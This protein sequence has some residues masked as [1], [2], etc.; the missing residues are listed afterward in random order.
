MDVEAARSVFL[1]KMLDFGFADSYDLVYRKGNKSYSA[2]VIVPAPPKRGKIEFCDHFLRLS[3]E[4]Q[5]QVAL[6]EI[7][8]CIDFARHG[9]RFRILKNGRKIELSHD[10]VFRSICR[11]I[12]CY[13]I[14]SQPQKKKMV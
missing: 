12:G 2:Q 13:D 9:R 8:H 5:V 7:A 11:E 6:H 1:E 4:E 3:R 10:V 14:F